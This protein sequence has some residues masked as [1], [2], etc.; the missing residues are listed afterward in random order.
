[1]VEIKHD[2]LK[3]AREVLS[4]EAEAIEAVKERLDDN[5]RKMIACLIDI[6][7]K[8]ILTGMGKSGII[9]RK[10][11]STLASTGTPSFFMHPAEASHG[12]LG[13]V[14]KEDA[15]IALSNSGETSELIAILPSVK[16][17]GAVIIG[18]SGNRNSRLAALSDFFFDVSVKKEAC[19]YNLAPTASTT[20]QLAIGDA[21]AVSLLKERGFMEEDFARLH[22]GGSI[23]KKFLKVTDIMHKG[24]EMPLVS[25]NA[26]LKEAIIEM[27][28]KRLGLTGVVDINNRLCG[29]I[30]DGDLRRALAESQ[31]SIKEK[32]AMDV[33]TRNPKTILKDALAINALK[34]MEESKITSLFA[35]ESES[36]ESPA[37]VIHIHD[38]VGVGII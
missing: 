2:I 5:F 20:V 34:K 33:M 16:L 22:P 32:R 23:G 1:M 36:D 28:S 13:M 25:E 19:P 27:N 9:A 6:K 8:V 18:L 12:D 29:I 37:G 26:S 21:L 17:I 14:S 3:T 15:I 11:S 10:I 31:E 7:G 4:I 35:V 24:K 38:I 30:V